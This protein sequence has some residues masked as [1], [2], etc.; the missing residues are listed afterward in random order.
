MC[1]H[2]LFGHEESSSGACR[3][4]RVRR[5]TGVLVA[6][7]TTL[8]CRPAAAQ[9]VDYHDFLHSV[10][11][12]FLP[13]VV[14][15]VA[16]QGTTAC[17]AN[18]TDGLLIVDVSD[19]ALSAIV[20]Q[21]DTPGQGLRVAARGGYAY[22]ADGTAGLQ[23]IDI[24][25]P[26]SP[27]VIGHTDTPGSAL[28]VVVSGDHAYVADGSGGLQIVD[29]ANPVAPEITGSADTPGLARRLA[30]F[31][32]HAYVG[33][34][35]GSLHVVDVRDPTSPTMVASLPAPEGVGGSCVG[36]AVSGGKVYVLNQ[37]GSWGGF[38]VSLL[39]VLDVTDPAAPSTIGSDLLSFGSA[40]DIAVS[41][42][43][44]YITR[45]PT[46]FGTHGW[47]QVV[48]VTNPSALA[49]VTTIPT[50]YFAVGVAL[51]GSA[52]YIVEVAGC[53]SKPCGLPSPSQMSG[54]LVIET[55]GP[56]VPE[57]V[58]GVD[59]DAS[60]VAVSGNYAYL[61]DHG[62]GI[63]VVDIT[64]PNAPTVV[65]HVDVPGWFVSMA[66]EGDH[67]YV[68]DGTT[69]HVI[70]VSDP[71]APR[72]VGAVDTPGAGGSVAVSGH[73]VYAAGNP[74]AISGNYAYARTGLDVIDVADPTA[75][76]IVAR[77]N[78][79][80]GWPLH[81]QVIDVSDPT[82]PAV[83]GMA[84]EPEDGGGVAAAG[85]Y[86]YA[87]VEWSGDL[88]VIDVRDPTA[89]TTSGRLRLPWPGGKIVVAGSTAYVTTYFGHV[90]VIDVTD[91]AAPAS[92]GDLVA[93]YFVPDVA[94]AGGYLYVAAD[95]FRIF[96]TQCEVMPP[97]MVVLDLDP[98]VI[99]LASR[100]PWVTAC[101][102]PVGF[103]VAS[104]VLSSIRIA[105]SVPVARAAVAGDRDG[106]G[107]PDLTMKFSRD[108]LVP[109]LEPGV[110]TLE[111]TGSTV[112]GETFRGS[113]AVRVS[114]NRHTRSGAAVIPHRL[115]PEGVL[116]FTTTSPGKTTVKIFDVQGRQVRVL[117]DR[118]LLP[119]GEHQVR[120][121]GVA[122][123]AVPFSSGLY[124]YRVETEEGTATGRIVIVR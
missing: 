10:G 19:P 14:T 94:V 23:V 112:T 38:S 70:D 24:S 85:D 72:V 40:T 100:A 113:D 47:L 108:L 75:P 78:P 90:L 96:R 81:L 89:P 65:G 16:V 86:V 124:F 67:A 76:E 46:E 74:V 51:A 103:D 32:G 111:V 119:P 59:G 30:V 62:S 102:E 28:D 104:I 9:C 25:Q 106:N 21:V 31:G 83:V 26:A 107:V 97:A 60:H 116:T 92:I 22:L 35:A 98:D 44:A 37:P 117:A 66:V 110:N 17:V 123:G 20:G 95:G 7:L 87:T 93:G 43:Y 69:L 105:G 91:P 5:S 99:Q 11:H 1:P 73:Y 45:V 50:R 12:L 101:I 8:I 71:A 6:L 84:A 79:P 33:V 115:D 77:V 122:D 4:R 118:V 114:D 29:I 121:D 27:A 53:G 68:S 56:A 42:G 63:R 58:G 39:W 34:G 88:V 52:A 55:G 49:V 2:A 48:D 82:A 18:G 61:A 109:L 57:P 54:L 36:V 80:G 3:S 15:D 13:G 120:I 64:D 41:D